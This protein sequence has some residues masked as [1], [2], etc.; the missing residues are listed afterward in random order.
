MRRYLLRQLVA[1]LPTLVGITLLTFIISHVAPADPVRFAAGP[2]ATQEQVEQLKRY[3]GV[4]QPLHLQYL[5]YLRGL[6]GGDW[7]R[8]IRSKQPVLADLAR[9]FPASLELVGA[10]IFLAVLL[11]VPLGVVSALRRNSLVDNL[12]RVVAV[13]GVALPAFWLG[14]LLQLTLAFQWQLFPA[15]G[16]YSPELGRPAAITGIYTLDALLN[17]NWTA[18]SDTLRHL[19]LPAFT[20]A[21]NPLATI[22]RMTRAS[23]LEVLSR[24]YIKTARASGLAPWTVITKYALKNAMIP[25]TTMIGLNVGWLLAGS[26]LVEAVFSWPGIGLY[27]VESSFYSDFQPIMGS[28]LVIGLTF[29]LVNLAVE[30]LYGLLDPRIRYG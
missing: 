2:H 21:V 22:T 15:V 4:D 24:D 30:A 7:G 27:T 28:T 29:L 20:L 19:A 8:S 5:N 9:Y 10:A 17:G 26:F 12:A 1:M 14:L 3:F 6:L 18:F 13:A 25:T 16:R 11:G 23:M